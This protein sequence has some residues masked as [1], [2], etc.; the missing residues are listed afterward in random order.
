MNTTDT[1]NYFDRIQNVKYRTAAL[2][3]V[4]MIRHVVRAAAVRL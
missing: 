4:S 2:S 1:M 3:V